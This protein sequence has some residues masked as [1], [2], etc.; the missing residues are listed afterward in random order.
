MRKE[1]RLGRACRAVLD[2]EH[3]NSSLPGRR[4]CVGRPRSRC[5]AG[6]MGSTALRE[7]GRRYFMHDYAYRWPGR[8]ET[9]FLGRQQGCSET[10]IASGGDDLRAERTVSA[11]ILS[12][13]AIIIHIVSQDRCWASV[14]P[15]RGEDSLDFNLLS[16]GRCRRWC[17]FIVQM[18]SAWS[19][20]TAFDAWVHLESRGNFCCVTGVG[21]KASCQGNCAI[22]APG[23]RPKGRGLPPQE[24][25]H[26]QPQFPELLHRGAKD[27]QAVMDR[28]HLATHHHQ[29]R[30]QSTAG[31]VAHSK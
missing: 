14:A 19:C 22:N 10:K 30:K 15:R 8:H 18:C 2:A 27:L 28:V 13:I 12:Y 26:V 7:G 4:A 1:M 3:A 31:A 24:P 16:P 17:A 11:N 29:G 9:S 5:W 23:T 20:S 25:Q 6:A 21:S